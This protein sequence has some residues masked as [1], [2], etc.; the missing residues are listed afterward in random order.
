M[1][2]QMQIVAKIFNNWLMCYIFTAITYKLTTTSLA[3]HFAS[4]T[5]PWLPYQATEKHEWKSKIA[6]FTDQNS[7]Y[8]L[9][10]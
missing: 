5:L 3:Y 2:Y 9:R 10:K 8:Y 7:L 1:E 6:Y 4:T